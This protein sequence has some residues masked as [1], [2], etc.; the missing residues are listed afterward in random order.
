VTRKLS[1]FR[2]SAPSTCWQPLAAYAA[3]E[4][5]KTNGLDQKRIDCF[6]SFNARSGIDSTVTSY[7]KQ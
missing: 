2:F 1:V 5:L 7:D 6:S 4:Q 3:Y